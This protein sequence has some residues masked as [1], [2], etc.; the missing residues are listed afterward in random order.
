MFP[1]CVTLAQSAT[2][3]GPSRARM[4]AAASLASAGLAALVLALG[5]VRAA[6]I[7]WVTDDAYISF[8]YADHL[9]R[10][11]GLVF[12][13]GERVEGYSNFLWTLWCALGLR[14]GFD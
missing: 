6:R 1:S 4:F 13:P 11:F 8:R 2:P 14:L 9:V 5:V 12:N 3:S 10:G 7:A